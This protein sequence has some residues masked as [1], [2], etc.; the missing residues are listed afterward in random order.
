MH[1]EIIKVY[2]IFFR[3][4]GCETQ[5][6]VQITAYSLMASSSE[7]SEETLGFIKAAYFFIS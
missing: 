3:K 2:N 7:H 1:G 4:V 5:V 6:W